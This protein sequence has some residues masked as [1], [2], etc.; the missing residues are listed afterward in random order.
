MADGL[1]PLAGLIDGL[2][3][4]GDFD[5]FLSDVH[6]AL[7]CMKALAY[8]P[9]GGGR[10]LRDSCRLARSGQQICNIIVDA[11]GAEVRLATEGLAQVVHAVLT[12][13]Q[14][15]DDGEDVIVGLVERGEAEP[16]IRLSMS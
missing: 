14:E 4:E 3:R 12:I 11:C 2:E 6:G 8:T 5:E 10:Q 15:F 13:V 1:L 16:R 7:N 9:A